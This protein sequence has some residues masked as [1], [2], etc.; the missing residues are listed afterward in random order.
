MTKSAKMW[1]ELFLIC[2]QSVEKDGIADAP[3]E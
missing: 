1:R 2:K 3:C